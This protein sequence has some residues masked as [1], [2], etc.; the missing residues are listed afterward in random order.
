MNYTRGGKKLVK[1]SLD[2]HRDTSTD[3]LK[4]FPDLIK[5]CIE[6]AGG[7]NLPVVVFWLLPLP[8]SKHLPF[9]AG[10]KAVPRLMGFA[11]QLVVVGS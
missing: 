8:H 7:R 2:L 5:V 9:Q 10:I 6:S 1:I 4:A 11:I 3:I